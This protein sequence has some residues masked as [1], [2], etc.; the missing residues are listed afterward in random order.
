MLLQDLVQVFRP[1]FSGTTGT[2]L[3]VSQQRQH[4]QIILSINPGAITGGVGAPFT[5]NVEQHTLTV[6]SIPSQYADMAEK[7]VADADYEP[8]TVVK[9][10]GPLE[11]TQTLEHA[12]TEVFGVII[13]T[14]TPYLMNDGIE[15]LP[16]STS[17]KGSVREVG[18]V[19]KGERLVSRDASS[20][21]GIRRR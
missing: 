18:K 5:G 2:L 10:G 12:D 16:S 7:Y 6:L 4:L 19:K 17:R 15:G 8:G 3:V 13:V 1:T 11:I 9:F 20:C 21:L 14:A